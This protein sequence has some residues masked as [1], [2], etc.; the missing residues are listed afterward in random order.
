MITYE[1]RAIAT[2][3]A[4]VSTVAL[5]M[6]NIG[7]TPAQLASAKR[8][9]ITV[10]AQTVRLTYDGSTPTASFGHALA[11]GLSSFYIEGTYNIQH[12]QFIR[13]TA[14]DGEV[15]VTLEGDLG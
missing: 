12:L 11:S 1:T 10:D 6:A 7:F 9:L 2:K 4:T 8:A 5:T 3:D 13:G 15:T 14:T